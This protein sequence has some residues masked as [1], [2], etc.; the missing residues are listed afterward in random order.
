M[1][2]SLFANSPFAFLLLSILL[3]A[4]GAQAGKAVAVDRLLPGQEFLDRKGV[5][6]TGLLEA[7]EAAADGGNHLGFATD[8]PA[9]GIARR[10]VR[11]GQR[12]AI[13]SD[14][15]LDAR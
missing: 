4:R 15:V 1:P 2:Y 10:Q 12:A 13:R 9:L 7:E 5:P 11:N 3:N 6:G 8:H 14:H